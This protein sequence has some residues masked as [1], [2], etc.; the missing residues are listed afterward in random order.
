MTSLDRFVAF[1]RACKREGVAQAEL[2]G[3]KFVLDPLALQAPMP[4]ERD[5]TEPDEPLNA[6]AGHPDLT[7]RAFLA[8]E[9]RG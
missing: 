7:T 4:V 5:S 6:P 2:D 3:M 8:A 1:V 9:G